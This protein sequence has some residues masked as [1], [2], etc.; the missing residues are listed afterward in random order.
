[1]LSFASAFT[2]AS[3]DLKLPEGQFPSLLQASCKSR[4]HTLVSR[5][6]WLDDAHLDVAC[7]ELRRRLKCRSIVILTPVL[8]EAWLHTKDK[9]LGDLIA[10]A[11]HV[12]RFLIPVCNDVL[13]DGGT[14]WTLLVIKKQTSG[15]GHIHQLCFVPQDFSLLYQAAFVQTCP[16]QAN[17]VNITS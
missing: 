8:A 2:A 1:M 12:K 10:D 9:H 15:A 17:L 5:T 3:A 4:S 16:S 7:R 11:E 14:H 6:S 13:Q